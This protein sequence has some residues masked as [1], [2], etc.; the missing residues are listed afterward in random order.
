MLYEYIEAILVIFSIAWVVLFILRAWLNYRIYIKKQ[1]LKDPDIRTSKNGCSVFF[2]SIFTL[3]NRP[4]KFED[5]AFRKLKIRTN[6]LNL[7]IVYLIPLPIILM[8]IAQIQY[9]ATHPDEFQP[10]GKFKDRSEYLNSNCME[11]EKKTNTSY[12]YPYNEQRKKDGIILLPPNFCLATSDQRSQTWNNTNTR[13]KLY[14]HETKTIYF[15]N[16]VWDGE[17][18]AFVHDGEGPI[19]EML[20]M[21]VH[22]V[23]NSMQYTYKYEGEKISKERFIKIM[24][25][26]GLESEIPDSLSNKDE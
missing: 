3:Y 8:I 5:P 1:E 24:E 14:S 21:T 20:S 12:G 19:L 9:L 26:W 15:D 4:S 16:G 7:L 11:S 2:L 10:N 17:F 18:D 6:L 23:N 22:P 13:G 25:D